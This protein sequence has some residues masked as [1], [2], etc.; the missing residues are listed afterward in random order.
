MI[1]FVHKRAIFQVKIYMG[2]IIVK[3][4]TQVSRHS[5]KLHFC[6]FKISQKNIIV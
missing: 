2:K 5:L 3:R 6:M 1:F 4:A